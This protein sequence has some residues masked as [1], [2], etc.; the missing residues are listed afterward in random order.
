MNVLLTNVRVNGADLS[1]NGISDVMVLDTSLTADVL[2]AVYRADGRIT[3]DECYEV[4]DRDVQ[5]Y[6]YEP[7]CLTRAEELRALRVLKNSL[8][9]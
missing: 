6:L 9:V 7:C 1:E 3:F 5:F 2:A 8:A 4:P